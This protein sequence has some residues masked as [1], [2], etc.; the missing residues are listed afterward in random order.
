LNYR[1]VNKDRRPR[2]RKKTDAC[3]FI[4]MELEFAHQGIKEKVPSFVSK[5]NNG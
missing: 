5:K 1:R 4:S 3:D 2:K